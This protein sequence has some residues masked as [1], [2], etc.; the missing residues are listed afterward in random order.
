MN[1]PATQRRVVTAAMI[2]NFV[3]WYDFT[4][5]SFLAV[6]ISRNFF[7]KSSPE[8]GLLSTLAVLGAGFLF[9]PIGAAV[10]GHLGD[11][12]GRRNVLAG[13]ILAMSTATFLVGVVP[14]YS[15][16][17]LW[18]PILLLVLRL[19][20]GLSAGGE[21]GGATSF[22]FEHTGKKRRGLVGSTYTATQQAAVAVSVGLSLG[23]TSLMSQATL[24][25]W[26]WRVLFITAMPIGLAGLYIRMSVPES[27]E[28]IAAEKRAERGDA[29]GLTRN[30]LKEVAIY[31]WRQVLVGTLVTASW[32]AGGYVTFLYLPTYFAG[33]LGKPSRS[34]LTVA[35]VGLVTYIVCILVAGRLSDSFTRWKVMF[36]GAIGLAAAAIPCYRLLAHGSM[37]AGS[38][39]VIIFA[40]VMSLSSGPTPAFLSEL[41]PA[42]VRNS[43]N[44]ISYALANT[45][46]A[47][48][49]PYIVTW[50]ILRSGLLIA[51]AFYLI[52]AQVVAALGLSLN[53]VWQEHAKP[54]EPV[55]A[56]ASA[57]DLS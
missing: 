14:A 34:G 7:P 45:L 20:Q 44:S 22:T 10:C 38:I 55:P 5:Y 39:A 1:R 25:G 29:D 17:G 21:F 49:A 2:G 16:I 28:F 26:G 42:S 30:P 31:R 6:Q 8:T 11:R 48:F 54:A 3:E 12:F 32:T 24:D 43:A 15:V 41:V 9:R 27:P 37:L 46:F 4:I 57:E 56:P 50:M 36:A 47:G 19:V 51:P 33:V 13:V 23:V 52:G 40:I 18:A 53:L 35:L